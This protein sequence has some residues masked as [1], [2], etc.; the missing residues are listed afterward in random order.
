[1]KTH[2]YDLRILIM[3]SDLEAALLENYQI[4]KEILT[5][6]EKQAFVKYQDDSSDIFEY[7]RDIL[8]QIDNKDESMLL[9]EKVHH[10]IKK[11]YPDDVVLNDNIL[12]FGNIFSSLIEQGNGNSTNLFF[13]KARILK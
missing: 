2:G 5:E 4:N 6:E 9:F 11:M 8:L 3:K 12:E 10:D 1:M 13:Q 7:V